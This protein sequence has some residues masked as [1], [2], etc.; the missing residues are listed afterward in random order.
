M[1]TTNPAKSVDLPKQQKKEM[2]ALTEI[3]AQRFLAVAQRMSEHSV[4]FA[5]LLGIGLR[6][7]EAFGL[8]WSDISFV[9]GELRVQRM[10][11]TTKGGW[12]FKPPKTPKSRRSI[13][14]PH[15][16]TKLL[17]EHKGQTEPGEYNLVF[18]NQKGNPLNINNLIHRDFKPVVDNA[19]LPPKLRLYDL[20][21]THATLLFLA[22]VHPKIVGERLGHSSITLTLDTYSH[23]LPGMQE[24]SA[25]KLNAMLFQHKITSSITMKNGIINDITN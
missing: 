4:L 8:Q 5:T 10:V 3:E 9:N 6:P 13:P 22:G 19:G 18:P 20:R 12:S 24:E 25:Q 7:S 11:S 23:V 2:L 17:L 16:L 21:H 15:D 1:I 14:L